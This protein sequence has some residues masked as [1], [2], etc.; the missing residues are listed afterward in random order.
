M[1]RISILLAIFLA[2]PLFVRAQDAA[3]EEQLNKLRGELT[4]LQA[5]NVDLQKRLADVMKELQ[6]VREQSAKP[7]GNY[8]SAEDLKQLAEKVREVDRK[9]AEDRELILDEIKK[10][11]KAIGSGGGRTVKK[12]DDAPKGN[13]ETPAGPEKGYEYV[14]LSGDNLSTIVAEYRRQ[15]VKVTVDQV[16]KANPGLKP[17]NLKVNQKIFIPAPAK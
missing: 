13:T 10:L 4:A 8:A 14:V 3:T 9:R 5:S 15:G 12:P 2:V 11:G 1:K 7:T 17:E 6:D 16:L